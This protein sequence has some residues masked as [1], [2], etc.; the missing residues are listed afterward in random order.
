M[1]IVHI[2]Y[3][4]VCLRWFSQTIEDLVPQEREGGGMV[5]SG[6]NECDEAETECRDKQRQSRGQ[7]DAARGRGALCSHFAVLVFSFSES[8][9]VLMCTS[10]MDTN[11]NDSLRSPDLP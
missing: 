9:C 3:M 2:Y 8:F 4:H 10:G 1:F 11:N 7:R 5:S 6:E